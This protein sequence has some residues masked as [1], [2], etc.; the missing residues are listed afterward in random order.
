MFTGACSYSIT[1][2]ELKADGEASEASTLKSATRKTAE[3]KPASK[4]RKAAQSD[5]EIEA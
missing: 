1:N 2:S 5:N 3:K 4:K